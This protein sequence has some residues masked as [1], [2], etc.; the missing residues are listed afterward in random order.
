MHDL[1]EQYRLASVDWIDKDAAARL[2]EEFKPVELARLKSLHPDFTDAKA[3]RIVRASEGWANFIRKMIDARTD[4][5][6][7]KMRLKIQEM[8]YFQRQ[9][10]DATARSER[11]MG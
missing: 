9:S 3:E 8:E 7:A 6:R 11:R 10:A 4:A 1:T 2:L 5:N